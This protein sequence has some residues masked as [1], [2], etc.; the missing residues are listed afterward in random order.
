M[1]RYI[2]TVAGTLA[3]VVILADLSGCARQYNAFRPDDSTRIAINHEVA[4]QRAEFARMEAGSESAEFAAAEA[5]SA[6]TGL[7]AEAPTPVYDY[8]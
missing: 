4:R 7:P 1:K 8:R 6:R 2:A 5:E 3:S